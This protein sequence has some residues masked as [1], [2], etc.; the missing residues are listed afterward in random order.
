[1]KHNDE[2][3]LI[4]KVVVENDSRAFEKLV[5]KY[6]SQIRR[7]FLNQTLGNAAL[8][9]DLAQ[10]TFI[11]AYLNLTS[12]K[13]LSGFS[14]WLYKIAFNTFYDHIRKEKNHN[15]EIEYENI[16]PQSEKIHNNIDIYNAMKIL[17]EVER[18]C[19]SLFYMDDLSIESISSIMELSEG[20]VKSHLSRGKSK[21]A[22]WL[23]NNGYE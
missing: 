11:K 6:Q 7:Y 19:I 2:L 20:T 8:S 14:T 1:M 15:K 17:K 16:A 23:K 21:M 22:E 12:F 13:S 4:A 3:S 9:D 18:S 5:K 10:E